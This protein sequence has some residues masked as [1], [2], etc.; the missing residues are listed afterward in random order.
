MN[1]WVVITAYNEED[2]IEGVVD[3]VYRYIKNIIVV[4]DFSTD[5][6]PNIL[7]NLP[8]LVINNK[9]NLGYARS[10][11]KGLK[12]AFKEGA[13]YAVSFDADGQHRGESLPRIIACLEKYRPDFVLGKRSSKNRFM[14]IFFELYSQIKFGF[15]DPLCGIKAFK[16]EIFQKYNYLE[17]RYTIGTEL[18]FRALKEG[19]SFKEV[20]IKTE[21]R[22]DDSR[23]GGKLKGNWLELKALINILLI[24]AMNRC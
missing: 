24:K 23:F 19:A 14:E 4:N 20:N 17:K 6:T 7:K 21:K 13:D 10:L 3:D 2:T 15:S 22:L 5:N 16:R 1:L 8:V 18:I 11:E 12:R 9:Q